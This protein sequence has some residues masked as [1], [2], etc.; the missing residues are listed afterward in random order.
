MMY[1]LA[2]H[3][4]GLQPMAKTRNPQQRLVTLNEDSQ[5]FAKTRSP[6]QKLV[7]HCK[8]LQPSKKIRSPLR[9]P[10]ALC[11]TRSSL[12]RPVAHCKDSQ[13]LAKT[14][15]KLEYVCTF[16]AELARSETSHVRVMFTSS[17]HRISSLCI[18][19]FQHQS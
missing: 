18:E 1:G 4:K 2:A 19:Q 9:R 7:A 5:P 6:L 12:R 16:L 13:P 14:R 3:C 10:V 11:K 17:K 15:L 8:Y